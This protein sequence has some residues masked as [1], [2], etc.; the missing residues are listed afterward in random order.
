MEISKTIQ[1]LFQEYE[2][3]LI[4]SSTLRISIFHKITEK[5]Y[6]SDFSLEFLRTFKLLVPFFTIKEIADFIAG[7]FVHNNIILEQ[8]E[9]YLKLC[10]ISTLPNHSNVTLFLYNINLSYPEISQLTQYKDKL[11]NQLKSKIEENQTLK[12][13]NEEIKKSYKMQSQSLINEITNHK[14]KIEMYRKKQFINNNSRKIKNEIN[15]DNSE[16]TNSEIQF[17][18]EINYYYNLKVV[19]RFF[20]PRKVYLL[21]IFPSGKIAFVL[22]NN[23]MLISDE[24]FEILQEI[25]E[26]KDFKIK[27]LEIKDEN[28]FMTCGNKKIILWSKNSSMFIIKKII[29]NTHKGIIY[30]VLF[31]DDDSIISCS[32]DGIIKIWKLAEKEYQSINYIDTDDKIF[33]ILMLYDKKILISCGKKGTKFWNLIN[34]EKIMNF[35][36][37]IPKKNNVLY[38]LSDD[39]VIIPSEK[40]LGFKII[41]ISERKVIKEIKNEGYYSDVIK[42][43]EKGIFIVKNQKFIEIYDI[44][45]YSLIEELCLNYKKINGFANLKN[46]QFLVY[47]CKKRIQICEIEK[48]KYNNFI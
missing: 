18:K 29:N 20:F 22:T 21:S 3:K 37:L 43:E 28:N 44:N 32:D 8:N 5:I 34:L 25:N 16:E 39:K 26:P 45:N 13:I 41:S 35:E 33:S 42:F 17:Q 23:I 48:E 19:K 30:K 38:R 1:T 9:E 36:E 12:K 15:E 4:P 11:L 6:K 14:K 31:N 2:I 10:L 24:K 47:G 7:L 40:L 46:G 27:H